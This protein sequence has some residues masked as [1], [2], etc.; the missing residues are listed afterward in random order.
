VP[1][2]GTRVEETRAGENINNEQPGKKG[3]GRD[4]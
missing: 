3:D 2:G 4:A 1:D